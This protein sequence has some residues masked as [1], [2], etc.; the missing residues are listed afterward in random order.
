MPENW[1]KGT[2]LGG[3]A[4]S[5]LLL[6]VSFFLVAEEPFGRSVFAIA[7][8]LFPLFALL[9]IFIGALVRQL[10]VG[11]MKPFIVGLLL[12]VPTWFFISLVIGLLIS[13]VTGQDPVW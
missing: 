7:V 4:I 11:D 5:A 12:G 1:W 10:R 2:Q 3:L 9:F 8:Y 13:M 6:L